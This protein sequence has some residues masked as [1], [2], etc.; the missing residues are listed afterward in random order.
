MVRTRHRRHT[1]GPYYGRQ[2]G[3]QCDGFGADYH[4]GAW[5][6]P[7]RPRT[8]LHRRRN[9][10][11]GRN[12][13]GDFVHRRGEEAVLAK[14]PSL[15]RKVFSQFTEH[16][17]SAILL[18]LFFHNRVEPGGTVFENNRQSD[19]VRRQALEL[20]H[21]FFARQAVAPHLNSNDA[22]NNDRCTGFICHGANYTT[23]VQATSYPHVATLSEG[24]GGLRDGAATSAAVGS[25]CLDMRRRRNHDP[26]KAR[27]PGAGPERPDRTLPS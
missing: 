19:D 5:H 23:R 9:T 6:G 4:A 8:D 18:P 2:A 20:D 24:R 3:Y 12:Q 22:V 15:T 11:D 27:C 26:A 13:R 16:H 25:S 17:S 21:Q 10:G 7:A 14:S 1:E